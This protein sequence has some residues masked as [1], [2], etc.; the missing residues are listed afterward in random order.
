VEKKNDAGT[1]QL[2]LET[3]QRPMT[4]HDLLRHTSGLTYGLFRKSLV[5]A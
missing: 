1:A 5:S 3:A 2:I 4:V